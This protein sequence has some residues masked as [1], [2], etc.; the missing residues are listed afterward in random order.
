MQEFSLYNLRP[1]ITQIRMTSW[2]AAFLFA[3]FLATIPFRHIQFPILSPF[4]PM[5]DTLLVVGDWLTAV[6]IF[7]Q[8]LILRSKALMALGTGYF[9]TGLLII[10]HALTFPDTFSHSGLLGA[11]PNTAGQL[12]LFWHAGLPIGTIAYALLRKSPDWPYTARITPHRMLFLCLGFATLLA[13]AIL[14]VTIWGQKLLPPTMVNEVDWNPI[15]LMYTALPIFILVLAAMAL[16]WFGRRSIL[17][18][19]LMLV[20]WAWLLEIFTLVMT[21]SRYSLGWYS[22]R[23]AA[24]LSGLFVLVMLIAETNR[25]YARSFLFIAAQSREKENRLMIR[26]AIAASVAHELRQPLAAIMLNAQTGRRISEG[27][28]EVSTIL[29]EIVSDCQRANDI[30]DTTR[31]IFGR[32]APRKAPSDINFLLRDTLALAYRDM[33]NQ[34][35]T[36]ELKLDETLPHLVVNR[37]QLQQVFLNLFTNAVEA[38]ALVTDRPRILTISTAPSGQGLLIRIED[39]GP[40][41]ASGQQDKVF[42]PFFTTKEHGTGMGL[43]ICLSVINAHGGHL[44]AR[45]GASKGAVFEIYLPYDGG[46]NAPR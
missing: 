34:G 17:D 21:G 9:F 35:V 31:A 15:L 23:S 20:L 46:E 13:G 41:F 11:G 14:S 3:A 37:L 25:L 22:G 32:A 10:P 39:T 16:I 4:I 26:D 2:P 40:G 29:G 38:M 27:A 33:R 36:A 1:S 24:V 12:Y 30:I 28:G 7:S 19:W 8:A 6:L 42:D 5:L 45:P 43:A 18:Y 44:R